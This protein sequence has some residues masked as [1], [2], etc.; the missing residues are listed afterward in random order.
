MI[1]CM[2]GQGAV[3]YRWLLSVGFSGCKRLQRKV[4]QAAQEEL[5]TGMG[6]AEPRAIAG[7]P[8]CGQVGMFL[9]SLTSPLPVCSGG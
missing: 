5:G 2:Q 1:L 7:W 6:L 8:Q 3:T 4:F 9:Q